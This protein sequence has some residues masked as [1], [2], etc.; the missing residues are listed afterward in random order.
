[1]ETLLTAFQQVNAINPKTRLLLIG[2]V[3]SLALAKAQATDYWQ[4]LHQLVAELRLDSAVHFTGYVE[5]ATAS[6][7]LSGADIGVLPFNSG[8]TLKSGSLLTLLAHGLPT[9]I[10]QSTPPDPNLVEAPWLPIVPPRY[11]DRLRESLLQILGFSQPLGQPQQF[12]QQFTW[13]AIATAHLQIYQELLKGVPGKN[14]STVR[15]FSQLG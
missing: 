6:R 3:E 2:G 14:H 10:T 8:V 1:L 9:V 13:D 7:Y 5:A 4:R 15:R 12:A 11:V